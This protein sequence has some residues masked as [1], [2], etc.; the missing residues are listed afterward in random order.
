MQPNYESQQYNQT[1]A[2]SY[3]AS[4]GINPWANQ[5]QAEKAGQVNSQQYGVNARSNDINPQMPGQTQP[6]NQPMVNQQAVGAASS[7]TAA[8]AAAKARAGRV[9]P[10]ITATGSIQQRKA[11]QQQQIAD[12][13]KLQQHLADAVKIDNGTALYRQQHISFPRQQPKAPLQPAYYKGPTEAVPMNS[14]PA[15]A[16]KIG[17]GAYR[18]P[19]T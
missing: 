17:N 11:L 7:A 2:S 5:Q 13:V 9:A 8:A 3:G 1:G 16:V 19:G 15:G 12:A 6:L 18:F 14:M 10:A 4:P